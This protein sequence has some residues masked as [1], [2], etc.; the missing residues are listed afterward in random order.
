MATLVFPKESYKIKL[1]EHA[2]PKHLMCLDFPGS[3]ECKK[4]ANNMG[5]MGLILRSGRSPGKGNGYQLQ[6]SDLNSMD[7][8]V[9]RV[10]KSLP[11]S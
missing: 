2:H 6:Y 3:S 7:R 10:A 4:S 9:H 5:D 11:A 8:I 1:T